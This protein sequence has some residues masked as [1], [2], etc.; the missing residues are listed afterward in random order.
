MQMQTCTHLMP[1][2]RPNLGMTG[3]GVSMMQV[4][5]RSA[6]NTECHCVNLV[7]IR[8]RCRVP[9]GKLWP[10]TEG[11]ILLHAVIYMH[12]VSTMRQGLIG[13]SRMGGSPV[14]EF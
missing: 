9:L 2:R 7:I 12:H 6:K 3:I 8:L 10:L 5:L 4:L 1:F 13:P 11:C 14:S